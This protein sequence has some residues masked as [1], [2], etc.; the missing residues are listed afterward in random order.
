M[1]VVAH[2]FTL[3]YEGMEPRQFIEKLVKAGV[4]TVIDVRELPLSRKAGFSK[5]ALADRLKAAG[6]EYQHVSALGCP[7][8]IRRR[9][10][11]DGNWQRYAREFNAYL[12]TRTDEVANLARTARATTSC[13][14][15]FEAD[16]RLCHRS[17]VAQAAARAGAPPIAH[18]TATATIADQ[19]LAAA[20]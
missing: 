7:K 11:V 10:K 13:L 9:Y 12:A 6:I 4:R 5:R 20:A 19:P 2:L 14:I 18:L 17:Y 16:F 3:G 8:A 1:K 15:C